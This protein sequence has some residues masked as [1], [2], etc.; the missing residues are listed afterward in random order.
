M[1]TP[2]ANDRQ[3]GGVHYRNQSSGLQH[4]DMVAMFNLDYFQGNIS[5]YVFRWRD[6]GGIQDLEKA[7]HYLDK[8][9]EL[10]KLRITSEEAGIELPQALVH[11]LVLGMDAP[12]QPLDPPRAARR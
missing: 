4:W 8:Y 2:T 11:Q 3:I 10:E 12:D 6:K 1:A 9:I 7:R 5:K